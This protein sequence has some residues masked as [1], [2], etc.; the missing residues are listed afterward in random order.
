M[1]AVNTVLSC[2]AGFTRGSVEE[3]L[4]VAAPGSFGPVGAR[5]LT[6]ADPPI[7]PGARLAVP[8]EEPGAAARQLRTDGRPHAHHVIQLTVSHMLTMS[9]SS[10]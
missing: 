9:F 1:V 7:V 10:R 2:D 5:P 4:A 8:P 3:R 6:C